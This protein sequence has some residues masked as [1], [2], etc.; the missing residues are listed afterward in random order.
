[1]DF[2]KQAYRRIRALFTESSIDRDMEKE[3]NAHIEMLA[4]K[5][6]Q[7]GMLPEEARLAAS[8]RFGNFLQLKERGHDV[9]GAGILGNVCRDVKYALRNLSRTPVFTLTVI[10]TLALGIGANTALF[11]V[12]DRLLLRP[13]PYPDGD[14]LMM[15]YESMANLNTPRN[16][17]SPANWLD[18]QRD[19]RSFESLA[20]WNTLA[21][22]LTGQGEP[23]RLNGEV[24][25]SEFFP[26]L[27]TL[28][29]LGRTF[30]STDDQA[31]SPCVVVLS[32]RLWQRRF[33][34]DTAVMGRKI[35]LDANSC[36]IVGVMPPEFRFV[37]D[38]IDYWAPYGLD[39]Q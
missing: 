25:W 8:R 10:M 33:G 28:P 32:H 16:V 15:L 3:M 27:R 24:V 38:Q 29:H 35:E 30:T 23:E 31:Q 34:G 36:E 4:E 39:R 9:K 6:E 14:Q 21:A 26:L 12:I 5:F 2:L 1:M 20:A 7:S 11:S 37:D 18:W 19:N 17:V 13:L 22:T